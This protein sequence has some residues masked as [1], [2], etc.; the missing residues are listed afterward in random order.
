LVKELV[1]MSL[2]SPSWVGD[3]ASARS[4]RGS[5]AVVRLVDRALP[6]LQ[7]GR[8]LLVLPNGDAIVRRGEAAGPEATLTIHRWRGLRRIL[9]D[10]EH[11]F[12]DGYLDGD[13]STPELG[14][15]LE[16]F[17]CNESAL[18]P[19]A[20][21]G[22]LGLARR[23][24]AHVWHAN[25]RRGS[26][27]N[28]AAHY[29]LGNDFFLPW[30]DRGMNYSSALYAGGDTLE[31]AQGR[32]LDRA[33]SLLELG[34]GE[35]VLEIG[36]GWG[37]LA[38][39]LIH[40]HGATVTGITLST[41]QLAYARTRLAGAIEHGRADLRLLDYRDVAGRFDRIASIEMI[42]AV[43]ERYW[44]VYFSK[45]RASLRSGGIALLQAITIDESRFA[46]YRARA[47]FIQRYIFSGGLL[48]TVSVIEREA[49]CAGLK[50][51]HWESFGDSYAK[52]LREWR[53][54][55]LRAWPALE[56][57]GFNERF[58]RM[59]EYYLAYCEIGFRFGV[60]DVGFFKLA[61]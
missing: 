46:A 43:G 51:V 20:E 39:Q 40:R 6:E 54:R 60:I 10:G 21:S 34:G 35:R 61:G 58:R 13:W 14:A 19:R 47:D 8:L 7:A 17:M 52:T 22:W 12:A 44:P 31:A 26:R 1:A 38:E 18:T 42:E 23:R 28:I 27:R 49:A 2:A 36:C 41:E 37:A 3:D 4:R 24:L 9:L 33:A 56:P 50:L 45:L 53:D 25:S 5:G 55:F 11:G 16:L 29:D 32:K 59:W 48:P 30:L 57:L 15:L